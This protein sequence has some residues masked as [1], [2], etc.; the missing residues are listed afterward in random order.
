MCATARRP[1]MG[2]T[3][4][5]LLV[6]VAIIALLISVLLPSMSKAREQGKRA[7]CLSRLHVCA[8]GLSAYS[9]DWK[10]RLP[11]RGCY[12][13]N[14]REPESWVYLKKYVHTPTPRIPVNEGV[15]YGKYTGKDGNFYYCPN[16]VTYSYDSPVAGWITFSAVYT[17]DPN[18]PTSGITWG[19][20]A[21]AATFTTATFPIEGEVKRFF[22][23]DAQLKLNMYVPKYDD[24]KMTTDDPTVG[25]PPR[26]TY[27]SWMKS[28]M[29]STQ[30][31]FRGRFYALM[32]DNVIADIAHKVG[33]NVLY[34]DYRAKWV[35][36]TTGYI[37][38]LSRGS[39]AGGT[40][41]VY[42][43]FNYFS[44]KQ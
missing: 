10:G 17:G 2:F 33:F 15:L 40:P 1:V 23:N 28:Q 13:Y 9:A 44:Q 7:V 6:V 30:K 32:S 27:E 12:T 43:T 41:G 38:S 18:Y 34:S 4:I 31:P 19:G 21:Y 35:G 25:F 11:V 24:P 29:L 39:G 14:I 3:L 37:R 22:E 16:N 26:P 8:V 42:A 20:Y 5:E 36:D